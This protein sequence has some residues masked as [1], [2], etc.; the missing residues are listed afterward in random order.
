M[1]KYVDFL[2]F[3]QDNIISNQLNSIMDFIFIKISII[4]FKTKNSLTYDKYII[5][6]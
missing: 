5:N 6:S 2:L 3:N 4:H 1:K